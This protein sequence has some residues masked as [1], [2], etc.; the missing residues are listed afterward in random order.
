M[1]VRRIVEI[2][3][4]CVACAVV[5]GVDAATL[6]AEGRPAPAATAKPAAAL[7]LVAEHKYRML[8][9]VRP[10]LF[11]ISKDDVGGARI[12]WRGDADGSF[13]LDVLIGS[14]PQR[15]P[16]QINRWGY[17]AEDVRG[18]EAHVV[19]VMKQSNEQ[20]I[21]D[22]ESQ[23]ANEHGRS[24]YVYRAIQGAA[25]AQA[26]RADVKTVR[27]ERDLTFRDIDPLLATIASSGAA[28]DGESRSVPLPEGTRPGFLIAL[29]DLVKHSVDAYG[30][31]TAS[32]K[33][34][35]SPTP[36][37]YYG[38]FYDL[39]MK[40]SELL[41]SAAIDGRHYTNLA[42]SEFEIRNR[43]N[44][45]TTK[46]QLT[47]GTSG[48]LAGVPVH[49]VYQPRWWFEVQLFLDERVAF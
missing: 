16:R 46:F 6:A 44:G 41:K 19:G 10:L 37:V 25:T 30:S 15:A 34:P 2:A 5:A 26:A 14:D 18:A 49:A 22:A 7:P 8:A 32:F 48:D 1:P 24:G 27:V 40:S 12:T 47:Y 11:W 38:V 45:E 23:L 9:K 29:Q 36:Y 35:K 31:P 28:R 43:S 20:S 21:A 4:W 39:T 33:P 3:A 17:I 42:R 13:G